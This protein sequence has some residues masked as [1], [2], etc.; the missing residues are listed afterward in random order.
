MDFGESQEAGWDKIDDLT[1]QV[2]EL[3]A[4]NE[5]WRGVVTDIQDRL[6]QLDVAL[7]IDGSLAA[8]VF[9]HLEQR[10]DTALCGFCGGLGEVDSGAPDPQGNFIQI[11]CQCREEER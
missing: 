4:D 7:G 2:K 6:H 9:R 5:R 1:A 10:V 3:E 8:E 11:P